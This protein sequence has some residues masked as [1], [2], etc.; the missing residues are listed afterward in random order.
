MSQGRVYE[1]GT[2]G[3]ENLGRDKKQQPERRLPE[4]VVEG[5]EQLGRRD[6]EE[7]DMPPGNQRPSTGGVVEGCGGNCQWARRVRKVL[8]AAGSVYSR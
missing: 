5:L 3:W 7:H 4:G 2:K 1:A 6:K 8:R